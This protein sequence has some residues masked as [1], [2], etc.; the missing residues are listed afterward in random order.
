V[1]I[2]LVEGYS[3]IRLTDEELAQLR[4]TDPYASPGAQAN[5]R[6]TLTVT[7]IDFGGSLSWRDSPSIPLE[8]RLADIIATVIDLNPRQAALREQKRRTTRR[9]SG[10][11]PKSDD[12]K[13][14]P[15][16]A[17]T[18]FAPYLAKRA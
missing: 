13:R 1:C 12:R 6:L 18:S 2:E 8:D 4:K 16:S 7:G 10:V 14:W 3:R 11:K 17:M 5:G 15:I 9:A